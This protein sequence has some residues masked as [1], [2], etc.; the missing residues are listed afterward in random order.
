MYGC[1]PRK[2]PKATERNFAGP[3][4]PVQEEGMRLLGTIKGSYQESQAYAER[5]GPH[6][7]WM[8]ICTLHGRSLPIPGSHLHKQTN[9][10]DPRDQRWYHHHC[11]TSQHC[12]R[13]RADG[14]WGRKSMQKSKRCCTTAE[15]YVLNWHSSNLLFL[16]NRLT[17]LVEGSGGSYA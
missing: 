10:K 1:G 5:R 15:R 11:E 7:R 2:C 9:S 14:V 17:W 13:H 16:T 8:L 6:K 4:V 3:S 12:P